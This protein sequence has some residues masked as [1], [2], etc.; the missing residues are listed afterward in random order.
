MTSRRREETKERSQ[1]QPYISNKG[2]RDSET[3]KNSYKHQESKGS[4]SGHIS[5]EEVKTDGA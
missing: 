1:L 4:S 3:T 2:H 5:M